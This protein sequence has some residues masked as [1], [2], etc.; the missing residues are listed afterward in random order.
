MMKKLLLLGLA[1]LGVSKL[2]ASYPD[3]SLDTF[4]IQVYLPMKGSTCLGWNSDVSPAKDSNNAFSWG[5]Y[6][7]G[8]LTYKDSKGNTET[9][10]KY[11]TDKDYLTSNWEPLAFKRVGKEIM[12]DENAK[13]CDDKGFHCTEL[14]KGSGKYSYS[15]DINNFYNLARINNCS[16]PCSGTLCKAQ[17]MFQLVPLPLNTTSNDMPPVISSSFGVMG[18]TTSKDEWIKVAPGHMSSDGSVVDHWGY[19]TVPG[20]RSVDQTANTPVTD[21]RYIGSLRYAQLRPSVTTIIIQKVIGQWKP[22][23]S[24]GQYMNSNFQLSLNFQQPKLDNF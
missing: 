16:P 9:Y 2:E 13:G 21:P 14:Y 7:Y 12:E 1:L 5:Y 24:I 17:K 22:E 4:N 20:K 8:P 15:C 18:R 6:A 10:Y 23:L 19:V 11:S 3:S